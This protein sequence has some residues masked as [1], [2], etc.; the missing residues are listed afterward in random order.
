MTHRTAFRGSR[1]LFRGEIRPALV[2]T[3]N[4]RIVS[5][6]NADAP[7]TGPV[8]DAGTAVILPGFVDT[9]AHINE[10]GRTDWEGFK[11]ATRACAAGGITTV[12]DMPLNSIPATTSLAS[13]HVKRSAVSDHSFVDFRFWG[14][15]VPGNAGELESMVRDN[16]PGFKCFLIESGVP[17]F[18]YSREKDLLTAMPVLARLGV[19]LLVH[20]ELDPD[21]KSESSAYGGVAGTLPNVKNEAAGDQRKYTSYL[22]SRPRDWENQAIRLMIDLSRRTGCR[23]HIVHLSSADALSDIRRAKD[24]GLPLT[25]ETCPHYLALH[26]EAIPDGATH[27]K[28]APPIR[29]KENSEKLWAGLADGTIDFVVSDHSPC[30]PALK[31]MEEGDFGRAWG[32]IS[33]LQ[34]APSI[35]WTE[36]KARGMSLP[37]LSDWMSARTADFAGLKGR[38]GGIAAGADADFVFFD[39]DAQFVLESGR[40]LHRHHVTPYAGRKLYGVVRN[41][42]LRGRAV[43]DGA[44]VGSSPAGREIRIA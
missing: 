19:P 43:Y 25:V 41:T 5:V 10:P 35:V 38:K 11:T 14:G 29:E 18:E 34:F 1:V 31:L 36:M 6:E 26:A 27:Y 32:G 23:V 30:T 2:V 8:T 17:E 20:A 13:L 12:V 40:I 3:E 22:K 42:I 21:D 7:F 24:D 33:S 28:C 15:V 9:H 4:G 37:Q 44:Q 16:V 39:P